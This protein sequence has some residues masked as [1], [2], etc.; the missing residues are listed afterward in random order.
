[1]YERSTR[2]KLLGLAHDYVEAHMQE[3]DPTDAGLFWGDALCDVLGGADYL[4]FGQVKTEAGE[5]I[6]VLP[7]FGEPVHTLQFTAEQLSTVI[8]ATDEIQDVAPR[9]SEGVLPGSE[10]WILS[11]AVQT[12]AAHDPG[13]GGV[14]GNPP[15]LAGALSIVAF[16]LLNT[17]GGLLDLTGT[18]RPPRLGSAPNDTGGPGS[19]SD[20]PWCSS[21]LDSRPG[22]R[23]TRSRTGGR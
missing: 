20:D 15:T 1:M 23:T 17:R 16:W 7:V 4:Q 6:C 12:A 8:A 21:T 18:A 2:N 19:E 10:D 9:S 13:L 14:R 22:L 3:F 11:F 5:V